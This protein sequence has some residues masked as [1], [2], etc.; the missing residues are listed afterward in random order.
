[1]SHL[2]LHKPSNNNRIINHIYRATAHP[3]ETA[4]IITLHVTK[5]HTAVRIRS[6][7]FNQYQHDSQHKEQV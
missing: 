1:M 3:C 6:S 7:K 5:C 4:C 2:M